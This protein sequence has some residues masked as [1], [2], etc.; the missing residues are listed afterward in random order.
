MFRECLLLL[1]AVLLALLGEAT[2]GNGEDKVLTGLLDEA[3]GGCAS[4]L[5]ILSRL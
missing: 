5:N 1:I 2:E 4:F 3:K